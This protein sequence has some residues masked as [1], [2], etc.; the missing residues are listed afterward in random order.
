MCILCGVVVTAILDNLT[1]AA[2]RVHIYI[3]QRWMIMSNAQ[4]L[5]NSNNGVE[6]HWE[7]VKNNANL[8]LI[9]DY[10][11][12]TYGQIL[13]EYSNNSIDEHKWVIPFSDGIRHTSISFG[14][15]NVT[16]TELQ[17]IKSYIIDTLSLYS[18]P[19]TCSSKVKSLKF[20][21]AFLFKS[22][23]QTLFQ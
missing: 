9:S 4:R 21:F 7:V 10:D 22:I 3:H 20:L 16:N 2:A 1:V 6:E 15:L 17:L 11:Y 23:I 14:G 13:S 12:N 18:S 19:S 5:L 8:D